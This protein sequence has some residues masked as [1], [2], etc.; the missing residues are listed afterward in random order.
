MH[1]VPNHLLSDDE[2]LKNENDIK[3]SLCD[4]GLINI[5]SANGITLQQCSIG[6][7]L[8]TI[9]SR[10]GY[11]TGN[12]LGIIQIY[13]SNAIVNNTRIVNNI[14]DLYTIEVN[15]NF[16]DL[17]LQCVLSGNEIITFKQK[18]TGSFQYSINIFARTCSI[19][20][21][22][23]VLPQGII[24]RATHPQYETDLI[25]ISENSFNLNNREWDAACITLR[26][27][28]QTRI[29]NQVRIFDN[30]ISGFQYVLANDNNTHVIQYSG[31]SSIQVEQFKS[32]SIIHYY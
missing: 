26:S 11:V 30:D 3:L 2:F 13:R 6:E 14:D 20:D 21:N 22:K 12:C 15:N 23:F 31:K 24:V 25:D 10:G 4:I 5:G 28:N 1:V 19:K 17:D 18:S 8:S 29:F 9:E 7:N 27:S 32:Q 16:Q